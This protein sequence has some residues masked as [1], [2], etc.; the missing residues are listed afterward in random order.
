MGCGGPH[1]AYLACRDEYKRSLPGRLVGVSVDAH[2]D[3]AYRLA[4]QTREQ[5][6]RREKATSQHLH[7]AGAAGRGRQHVR[8]LPR[9]AG[10]EAHRASASPAY[11]AILAAGPAAARLHRAQRRRAF[12]TLDAATPARRPRRW[13]RSARV[14][15][16]HEPA[17]LRVGRH[18]ARHRARRDH[19]ARRHR[20]ALAR[21][22]ASRARRCPTFADVRERHRAADSRRSCA[23]PAPSSRTR[24]STRTTARPRCCA[25]CARLADKDLAL[26]RS[27]DPAGLAAR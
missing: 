19:D 22:R 3:P 25:T 9:P 10:P 15:A 4:L 5:H 16:R 8:R 11:T 27:D 17:P 26:D 24:S 14:A 7:G 23:A 2:G 12:D 20:R 6:I 1:A 21:L 18:D 13:S